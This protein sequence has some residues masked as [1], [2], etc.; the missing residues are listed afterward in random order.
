MSGT[1]KAPARVLVADDDAAV[2]RVLERHLEDAGYAVKAA[3]GGT[4]ALAALREGGFAALVTDLQMPGMDGLA[5]LSEAKRLDPALPVVVITAHGS[6]ET[7]VD[8][9][10][11]GA[12]DYVEKPF[13]KDV[14]LLT[15]ERAL[16]HRALLEENLR[17]TEALAREFSLGNLVGG[18][19]PMQE[20]FR[21]AA[22]VAPTEA[23]LLLLGE[24]GTG[25]ELLAR[26]VHYNSSRARGPF[27]TV[28][29][30]AIPES[31]VEAE[32]FGV[33]KGAFTGASSDR[34]GLF[35]Q[36][37]GGTLFLDEI[38]EMRSD[39]QAKL[40]RALDS[41]EV[42]PVG[43]EREE[44]VE[45]RVVA[46]TNRDLAAAV[47][48]GA[49]RR[50]LYHRIAVVVLRLPPLRDRV[51]DLPLLVGHL[52]AK[53][54]A[55]GLQVAP[56]AMRLLAAW[57]WPG[58]VREL[59]NELRRA[60]LLRKDPARVGPEDLAAE[61]RAGPPAGA[62]GP[63]TFDLRAVEIPEGGIDL[64]ELERTLLR[65]A[66]ERTAGNQTK[67]AALLG[68]TRQTLIYRMEK[69]GLKEA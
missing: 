68:I 16:R 61:I 22:R 14:L 2:R 62:R 59:E 8:A 58:N 18:S 63:G 69:H 4:T 3:D 53:H 46:A 55:A 11:K 39:L 17:L 12:F 28:N 42:R 40:L 23:P 50:D 64:A 49:F 34:P 52:L 47:E 48:E 1:G 5:L 9:M 67:A 31:L 56:E 36:A 60:V 26:A 25:K 43:G 20:V 24:S 54:G 65:K 21:Q 30:A 32:L 19:P 66:L 37:D 38:G 29:V 44:R 13:H 45:V 41:G 7:A 35:R 27:V 15:L 10:R 6:V 57:H 33:V 51:E